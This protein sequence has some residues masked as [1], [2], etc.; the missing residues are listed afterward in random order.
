MT[1]RYVVPEEGLK[2]A[3][4]GYEEQRRLAYSQGCSG[5]D[6]VRAV[7]EAFIR[8]QSENLPKLRWIDGNTVDRESYRMG[9]DD[10]IYDLRR[11][12][13]SPE[14]EVDRIDYYCKTGDG[15]YVLLGSAAPGEPFV[16]NT[17]PEPEGPVLGVRGERLRAELEKRHLVMPPTIA[18]GHQRPGCHRQYG[19]LRR[20]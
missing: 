10:T 14:P 8:W 6:I 15:K 2:A 18:S 16:H 19:G 7:L 20:T 11:M 12:Y 1:Q 9:Y 4:V 5:H 3:A 17:P 13:L